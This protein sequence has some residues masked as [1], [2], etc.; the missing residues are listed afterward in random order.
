MRVRGLIGAAAAA[1]MVAG[2]TQIGGL[3]PVS[4]DSITMLRTAAYDVLLQNNV[5]ILVAPTCTESDT[6]YSC[7]G[8]TEDGTPITVTAPLAKPLV[9]TVSV[10]DT[11]LYSGD[12]TTVVQSFAEVTP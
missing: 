11:V 1:L 12:V 5:P 2:C 7:A 10:G 9:M 8:T 4:G 3:A 6:A